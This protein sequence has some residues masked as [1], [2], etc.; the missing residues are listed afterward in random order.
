MA[1]RKLELPEGVPA[2]NSYYVYMTGGCNLACQHCWIAP[3]YQVNGGTGGHL[4]YDLF[5]LA[6]EEGIPLGLSSVKLTGGE[7]L[8]HPDFIRIVDLLR[9]KELGLTIETNGTLMTESLA[10][11]L[12]EK[13]TLGFI[14]I[15][16][17]GATAAT[18]DPFR[19]VK[20][21]FEKAVQ[22]IRFLVAVGNRPQVIMSVH[23]GNVDEIEMLVR[24]AEN[25]GAGSVKFNIINSSGRGEIFTKKGKVLDVQ[26][27]IDL[28]KWIENDL[29]RQV[30]IPLLYSWPIAFHSL[31][32]LSR[33]NSNS[34]GII[35]ILGI[36]S[37]GH[38]AMCGIGVQVPELC[39]GKIST[40][41]V[42]DLW[43][44]HPVIL[45]L[46]NKLLGDLD[47]VCGECLFKKACIG[48]CIAENYSLSKSLS[49]PFWFCAQAKETGAF[50][51]SRL[52]TTTQEIYH[53]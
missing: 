14:S 36:L 32:R 38:L 1:E 50:P 35:N 25:L 12:K 26:R 41:S 51:A 10:H 2:L 23:V 7:P 34:C 17:D 48:H 30:S 6:I 21:S 29:Q 33:D 11:Y 4:D 24:L 45:D 9:E 46:R 43:I 52:Y 42:A 18:H 22:G 8:L 5:A 37:T 16:L 15:S 28:G 19:G 40:D 3:T 20:G 27:L 31:R 53:D 13:S 44:N 47:G 49:A 39:Y